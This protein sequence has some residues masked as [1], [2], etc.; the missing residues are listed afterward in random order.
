[1]AQLKNVSRYAIS[2]A[3]MALFLYWAFGDIDLA[4][5]W[6]AL[7]GTSPLWIAAL[8]LTTLVTLVLR[9]WRWC[10]LMRPFARVSI[11]DASLALAICY[12]GNVVI[13]RSGELLRAL[14]LNW[15]RGTNVSSVLATVVV[16]RTL[17]M[18]FLVLLVGLSLLLLPGPIEDTFPWMAPM[19]IVALVGCVVFIA[20]LVLVSRNREKTIALV[21][22]VVR[23]FS[24][25]LGNLV[26]GLLEK[27]VHGLEALHTPSAY[28][29]IGIG[30]ILLNAG[31]MLIIYESFMA[32]DFELAPHELGVS[33]AVVILAISS[34][35]VVIPTP[36]GTGTYH[37]F[38][39]QS[40]HLLFAIP[41]APALACAT[42]VHAMATVT[43][44]A[45]GGPAFLLQ[46]SQRKRRSAEEAGSVAHDPKVSDSD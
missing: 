15:T 29:E 45:L 18:V 16:E 44:L 43:Y 6:T 28:L 36:G 41:A 32:F 35:G 31:Y 4:S 7:V 13:P 26:T 27:F 25:R 11:L 21:D 1:M 38:F 23:R 39:G 10:V 19:A 17:D 20:F 24:A 3:L 22:S 37:F 42:L 5:V 14:S 30:S 40:L 34:L 33:A 9:A 12:S 46:R 2:L 8:I